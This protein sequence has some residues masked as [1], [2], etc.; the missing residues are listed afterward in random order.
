MEADIEAIDLIQPLR[1][2][3][4]RF[5]Y[6]FYDDDDQH[7]A[8]GAIQVTAEEIA[9]RLA[10]Y[11]LVGKDTKRLKYHL[12]PTEVEKPSDKGL[13]KYPATQVV[14]EDGKLLEVPENSGVACHYHGGQLHSHSASIPPRRGR[15]RHSHASCVSPGA[16]PD[17]LTR[18]AAPTRPWCLLAREGGDY[19]SHRC[20]VVFVFAY[21]RLFG[22]VAKNLARRGRMG[23]GEP[24][25]FAAESLRRETQSAV[26]STRPKFSMLT[27]AC[28]AVVIVEARRSH[29]LI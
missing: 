13:R 14:G 22:T 8:D 11:E 21:T 23:H 25:S 4:T 2:A 27:S 9:K 24:A 5:P 20:A 29:V 7:P 1:A 15:L 28:F 19:L 26:F 18:W 16:V 6:V 3:R 10:R 12:K 17:N